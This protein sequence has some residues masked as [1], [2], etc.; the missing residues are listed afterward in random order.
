M[1]DNVNCVWVCMQTHGG[2]GGG[3]GGGGAEARYKKYLCKGPCKEK[4]NENTCENIVSQYQTFVSSLLRVFVFL[5]RRPK[6]RNYNGACPTGSQVTSHM[7][8]CSYHVK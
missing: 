6:T 3:G 7:A 2:G 5:R 1:F 4:S 8:Q